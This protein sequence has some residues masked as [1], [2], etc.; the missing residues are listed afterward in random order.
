MRRRKKRISIRSIR[1]DIEP[2]EAAPWAPQTPGTK[3]KWGYRAR[4]LSGNTITGACAGSRAYAERQARHAAERLA[5][6]FC[7]DFKKYYLLFNPWI[8]T[9]R[10]AVGAKA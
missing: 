3:M 4:S 10:R 1:I 5:E 2:Y 8:A 9:K 6:S 7:I